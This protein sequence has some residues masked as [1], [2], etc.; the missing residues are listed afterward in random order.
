MQQEYKIE[1]TFIKIDYRSKFS[2]MKFA[3]P[4]YDNIDNTSTLELQPSVNEIDF[5]QF[6]C[7]NQ[8]YMVP[9]TLR[10]KIP[11]SV[12]VLKLPRDFSQ[13][14]DPHFI[15]S[16]VT[17]LFLTCNFLDTLELNCIPHSVTRLTFQNPLYDHPLKDGHLPA[18]I[19]TLKIN[20]KSQLVHG[21]IPNSVTDLT[22]TTDQ[23]IDIGTI[24]NSVTKLHFI[25]QSKI[26]LMKPGSIPSSVTELTMD[27]GFKIKSGF[28]PESVLTLKLS[29]FNRILKPGHLPDSITHLDLGNQF[30]QPI[31]IGGLPSSI[32]N[33]KLGKLFN[34]D[35]KVGIFP[36]GI[37]QIE[38]GERFDKTLPVDVFPSSLISLI[39][40][41]SFKQELTI[42]S[43]PP[44]L[45]KLDI[46]NRHYP[47][48][49][50]PLIVPQSLVSLILNPKYG[51]SLARFQNSLKYLSMGVGLKPSDIGLLPN[52]L[53]CLDT[54]FIVPIPIGFIPPSLK[55]LGLCI[56]DTNNFALPL[57]PGSIPPTVETLV[58]STS[59]NIPPMNLIPNGIKNLFLKFSTSSKVQ[60]SIKNI[61]P[62]SV[63]TLKITSTYPFIIETDDLPQNLTAIDLQFHFKKP[64]LP[65]GCLDFRFEEDINYINLFKFTTE[66]FN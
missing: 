14:L 6:Q 56:T 18:S 30:N 27:L 25:S 38:F 32:K 5:S 11:S 41:V 33:L 7:I 36:I 21:S 60:L 48:Y 9:F 2:H 53:E 24:P 1:F 13:K 22:L 35:I 12:T 19:Q 16:S 64:L 37:Q 10:F 29:K 17:S 55:V 44:G 28:I 66:Q 39:L 62:S 47:H 46:L 34:Q 26:I 63:S 8:F 42:G 43:L 4:Q 45:K 31:D 15:P 65:N 54:S 3:K 58:I 51:F 49:I 61:I 40:G 57:L 23:M 59:V 20:V 52:T 50:D